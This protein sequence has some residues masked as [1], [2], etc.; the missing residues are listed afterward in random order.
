VVCHV[1][2]VDI[3]LSMEFGFAESE[4]VGDGA[5]GG[6]GGGG[7]ACFFLQAP[8]NMMVPR[9]K[10]RV[11][12]FTIECFTNLLPRNLHA[13]VFCAETKA[14]VRANTSEAD[15]NDDIW[16]CTSIVTFLPLISNSNLVVSCVR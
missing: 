5:D 12:H 3:P 6:G 8:R 11:D 10:T 4:A 9:T 13:W 16:D 7:G 14:P 15:R 2:V 1:S